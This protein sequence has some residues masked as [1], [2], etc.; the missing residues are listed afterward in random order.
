MKI[1]RRIKPNFKQKDQGLT[2]AETLVVVAIIAIF[3]TSAGFMAFRYFADSSPKAAKAQIQTFKLALN[4]YFLD[5]SRYPTQ[6]QGLSS[7]VAKPT[8]DPIPTRWNGPYL[9]TLSIP[10]DPW[11]NEYEYQIPGPGGMPFGVVSLGADGV[12]GGEGN[13]GDITSWGE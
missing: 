8:S 5:S 6:E 1:L 4:T 7:L 9:D 13:D 3:S 10:T 12:E 11:G 2:L